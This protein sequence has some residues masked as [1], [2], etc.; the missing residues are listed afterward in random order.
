VADKYGGEREDF[1]RFRAGKIQGNTPAGRRAPGE[2]LLSGML[3]RDAADAGERADSRRPMNTDDLGA[4][5]ECQGASRT[6]RPLEGVAVGISVALGEDSWSRGFG[7]DEM[8]RSVVRLSDALLSEGAH[9]VFGH[10]W[11]ATGVMS[12][13]ARLAVTYEPNTEVSG[14]GKSR[15]RCRITNLVPW[16]RRPELPMDLRNDLEQRGMLQIVEVPLPPRLAE[17][18]GRLGRRALRAAALCLMRRRLA[19]LCDARICLGG[20]YQKYEGFYP[21]I[22]EEAYTSAVSENGNQ[23]LLSEYLGGAA[24]KA[25][26]GARTGHWGSLLEVHSDPELS[27]GFK[28][29]TGVE[30]GAIPD[31]RRAPEVLS[32][33]RLQG[34]SGLSEED[35]KSFASARDIEAICALAIKAR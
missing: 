15:G 20:K 17:L 5:S 11:R 33:N 32:W 13:V 23:V 34:N 6:G 29:L 1:P 18:E 16:D 4:K 22:V 2:V 10:D 21:G 25:L 19:E 14:R 7:E 12:A 27:R 24:A 9:L 35:W 26:E 28:E 3:A 31:L 8:N 30:G